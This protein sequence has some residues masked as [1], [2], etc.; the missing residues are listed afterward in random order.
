MWMT[1]GHRYGYA[2]C[3][4]R[5]RVLPGIAPARVGKPRLGDLYLL[6]VCDGAVSDSRHLPGGMNRDIAPMFLT[7]FQ[8]R[9]VAG[10][11]CTENIA[12]QAALLSGAAGPPGGKILK[13]ICHPLR[14]SGSVVPS[15][16]SMPPKHSGVPRERRLL[17][18][19]EG[20]VAIRHKVMQVMPECTAGRRRLS[21]W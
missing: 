1:P 3:S 11:R 19:R 9:L 7:I 4:R 17:E 2:T 6:R 10:C 21:H 5:A 12:A 16:G 13:S 15:S 8:V 20:R 18:R 14:C